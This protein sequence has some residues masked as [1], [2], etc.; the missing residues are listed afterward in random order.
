MTWTC[1]ASIAARFGGECA[2]SSLFVELA[3][4][5]GHKGL[6]SGRLLGV[7]R[8]LGGDT[9]AFKLERTGPVLVSFSG[10]ELRSIMYVLEIG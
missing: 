2:A 3:A 10:L 4:S 9:G 1:P 6:L 8:R 5:E 7:A